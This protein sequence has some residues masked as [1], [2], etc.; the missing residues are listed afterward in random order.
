MGCKCTK[1]LFS[2]CVDPN[3]N[4]YSYYHDSLRGT[5][6]EMFSQLNQPILDILSIG[7]PFYIDSYFRSF[8][9]IFFMGS[10]Y[11]CFLLVSFEFCMVISKNNKLTSLLGMLLISFSASTQ[12]WQCY[13]IFYMGNV[14][15]SII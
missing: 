12:W 4:N 14:S 6:T 15:Y 7:K 10:K 1:F 8:K 2:Q 13:N 5:K 11:Y 9:R 3:G